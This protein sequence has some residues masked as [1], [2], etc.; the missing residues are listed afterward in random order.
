MSTIVSKCIVDHSLFNNEKLYFALDAGFYDEKKF[1]IAPSI[2]GAAFGERCIFLTMGIGGTTSAEKR[3][4]DLYPQCRIFGIE[5]STD[6]YGDFATV[7]KILP[8][9]VGTVRKVGVILR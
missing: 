8:F 2:Q 1:F 9:A 6:A 4:H 3:F 7:G 5:G